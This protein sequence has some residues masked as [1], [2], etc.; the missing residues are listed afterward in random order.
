MASPTHIRPQVTYPLAGL[1]PEWIGFGFRLVALLCQ[2][3][4][5]PCAFVSTER[6]SYV[7]VIGASHMSLEPRWCERKNSSDNP[8]RV[9]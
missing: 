4:V 6:K 2:P 3:S 8:T 1:F 5:F 7:V 9:F